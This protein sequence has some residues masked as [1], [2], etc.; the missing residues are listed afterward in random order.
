ML[1]EGCTCTLVVTVELEETLGELAVVQPVGT[2]HTGHHSLIL[3]FG[4]KG[5]S[6]LAMLRHKTL[7]EVG[8][9]SGVGKTVEEL[10]FEIRSGNIIVG[11][12]KCK[13]VLEHSAGGT[14]CGHKLHHTVFGVGGILVPSCKIGFLLF[15]CG[16]VNAMIGHTGG[17]LKLEEG[18]AGSETCKLLVEFFF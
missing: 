1:L 10:L 12:E 4:H 7:V 14:G 17:T 15:G 13:H 3:A 8:E 11:I 16:N 9:E 2:E 6:I 18:E 5:C